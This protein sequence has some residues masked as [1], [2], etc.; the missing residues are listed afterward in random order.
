[1]V[2]YDVLSQIFNRFN[3][4]LFE[5]RLGERLNLD[6]IVFTLQR[7]NK[8]IGLLSYKQ[9]KS[10][11]V[12]NSFQYA[13]EISLNPE[14]LAIA[15]KIE[16]LRVFCQELTR[17]YRYLH[18]TQKDMKTDYYDEEFGEF[19]MVIGLHPSNTGKL[20]GKE[21]GKKMSSYIYPDGAFLELC[22]AMAEEDLLLNWF[23]VGMPKKTDMD[24]ILM[25]VY[26]LNTDLNDCINT[27]LLEVP[28]LQSK[29]IT[30]EN[31]LPCLE[32]NSESNRIEINASIASEKLI[33]DVP[34][35]EPI[36][37][38]DDHDDMFEQSTTIT[39]LEGEREWKEDG[40][41]TDNLGVGK[42]MTYTSSAYDEYD[43]DEEGGDPD[44]Y[45]ELDEWDEEPERIVVAS[46]T[47]MADV[48]GIK[49]PKPVNSKT[50]FK[51]TCGCEQTIV[52][53]REHMRIRCDS[54]QMAFRCE[55][56][57]FESNVGASL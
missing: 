25:N 4:E 19:L 15:P 27:K 57:N 6:D 39:R 44:D 38:D 56:E 41:I 46:K 37:L 7:K 42:T 2:I 45:N 21:V 51:Y 24:E 23:D 36:D 11:V 13:H 35:E 31:L 14:Y 48:I 40:F 9:F 52:A 22:N 5:A 29:N 16:V 54:C 10:P 26:E 47:S 53:D 49:P 28:L 43:E 55:T 17:L 33:L 34:K 1:M 8:Q 30:V 12:D 18:G 50:K 32:I 20:G 3:D